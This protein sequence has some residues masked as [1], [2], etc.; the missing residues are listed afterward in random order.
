M[1]RR[2]QKE[3]LVVKVG[4]S[5]A[6]SVNRLEKCDEFTKGQWAVIGLY[7]SRSTVRKNCEIR[8]GCLV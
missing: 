2:L 1:L 5:L 6:R 3:I 7:S 4:L 8:E